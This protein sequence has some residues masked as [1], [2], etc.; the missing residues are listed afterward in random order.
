MPGTPYWSRPDLG[1]DPED[2]IVQGRTL[3]VTVHSLGSVPS[4]ETTV[5]LRDSSGKVL[6]SEKLVG[7]AA[8]LDLLPKTVVVTFQI[9]DNIDSQ[10]C[11]VE[12]DPEQRLEE[13]TRLNNEVKLR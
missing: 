6:A 2:V 13:I 11:R 7:I 4:P 9:P 3:Q 8:P 12:I 1:I 5:A 10:V